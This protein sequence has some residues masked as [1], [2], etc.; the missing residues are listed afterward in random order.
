MGRDK[1]SQILVIFDTLPHNS[2]I[3]DPH[4]KRALQLFVSSVLL[5]SAAEFFVKA[6][7][8]DG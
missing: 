1:S 2:I 5:L 7:K 3:A 4:T 8:C 6:I